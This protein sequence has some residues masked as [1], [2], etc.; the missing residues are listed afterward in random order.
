MYGESGRH[1]IRV[2]VYGTLLPGMPNRHIIEPYVRAMQPGRV[3]GRLL[4]AGSYP[5][6]VLEPAIGLRFVRGN[7]TDIDADG[8]PV[9]DE[10]EEFYGIEEKNDYER[11][12][13]RDADEPNHEGWVYVWPTARGYPEAAGDWW[14]DA[15][16][17]SRN[18]S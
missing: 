5:A 6:L 7:W 18:R 15:A 14:P 2:F 8:L 10:L 11:V 13:I 9:L 1:T 12:W 4:D 17:N 3:R 16:S